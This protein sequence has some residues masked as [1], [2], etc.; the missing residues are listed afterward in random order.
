[1]GHAVD[2]KYGFSKKYCTGAAGGGWH[3]YGSCA[4]AQ[5]TQIATQMVAGSGGAIAS[6]GGN[7][8]TAVINA[9]AG[10]MNDGGD[11][12]DHRLQT[13][14]GSADQATAQSV[15]QDPAAQALRCAFSKDKPWDNAPDGGI[16]I[17]GK[18]YQEAYQGNWVTYQQEA[19]A[20]RVSLY[21][22]RAPGEW[23]AEAYAAYYE[24]AAKGQPKGQKLAAVDPQTKAWFDKV[25][26][27]AK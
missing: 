27:A 5:F 17:G 22:F 15:Q 10:A 12:L 26:D 18:I 3:D 2:A 13:A 1:V 14:L 24:P 16:A 9:L 25:V 19:R 4:H 21:Q 8:K 11:T 6:L 7:L 20:R 23:F